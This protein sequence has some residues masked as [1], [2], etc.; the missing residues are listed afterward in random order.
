MSRDFAKASVPPYGST[1]LIDVPAD[2]DYEMWIG[3]APMKPYTADR[4]TR[5]GGYH[6]YDYALGYIAGWGAH[7]L[8]IAQ[9]GLDMD[10]SGPV[11]YQGSGKLPPKG[12]LWNS[13]ESW[14]VQCQYANG[15]KMHFMGSR[16]AKPVVK[17]YHP[18]WCDHG[19]TFFGPKGWINVNRQALY[20]SSKA[21]QKAEIKPSR[22][23]P[24]R[25]TVSRPEFR[26][27][28]QEPQAHDQPAGIGHSFG[29]HQPPQRHMHPPGAAHPLGPEK[30][31]DPRRRRGQQD[32]GSA[33]PRTVETGL[34]LLLFLRFL[35]G[36]L[37]GLVGQLGDLGGGQ[38]QR[39]P[40]AQGREALAAAEGDGHAQQPA[41]RQKDRRTGPGRRREIVHACAAS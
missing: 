28:H 31:A 2:L 35:R 29:H 9:W 18:A 6:I 41:V 10:E 1:R 38:D 25:R 39:L 16:V 11:H 22:D 3:P 4:A 34:V 37:A 21:L 40:R 33:A 7:P 15:V 8:D 20:A 14:D 32:V 30:G 17:A 26:R 24:A 13:I 5:F 36:G 23:P 27:L 19:T 12:S